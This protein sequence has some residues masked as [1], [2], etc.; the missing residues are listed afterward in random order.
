MIWMTEWINGFATDGGIS[1]E[2]GVM[3][4]VK[5]RWRVRVGDA[6]IYTA[7]GS[8]GRSNGMCGS[9]QRLEA[10]GQGLM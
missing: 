4:G 1:M 9:T 6:Y 10:T 5:M 2:C 7:L 3:S 8:W